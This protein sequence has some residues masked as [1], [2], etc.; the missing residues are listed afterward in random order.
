MENGILVIEHHL[1]NPYDLPFDDE[2]VPRT[3]LGGEIHTVQEFDPSMSYCIEARVISHASPNGLVTSFFTYGYD[4]G[5]SDEID[6]EFLSNK[7]NDDTTYPGGDPLLTNP[8]NESHQCPE[9]V[10]P[11]GL[12]LTKWN[13]F[14]IYWYPQPDAKCPAGGCIQWWWLDPVNGETWL[15]TEEVDS[16]VPDEPMALYFNF[17][18]PCYTGWGNGCG[19]WDE[20][21]DANLQ[22]VNTVGQNQ[23]Y[24]YEIDYVEVR[25][26]PHGLTESAKLPALGAAASDRFGASF[27]TSG[28]VPVVGAPGTAGTDSN[29]SSAYV[30]SCAPPCVKDDDCDDGSAC[31][32]DT[33]VATV[34]CQFVPHDA[35]PPIIV[36]YAGHEGSTRPCSGYIDPRIE[37]SNGM[38]LDRGVTSVD[39]HFS[40]PVYNVCG[41]AVDATSFVVTETGAGAQPEVLG[42]MK[43]NDTSYRLTLTRVITL[44]EW[45]TIRAAV[46]DECGNP[47]LNTG[48]GGPNDEPDRVDV[49]RLPGDVDQNAAVQ[50]V[51]LIRFRQGCAGGFLASCEP[52]SYY[53]DIDRNEVPCQPV[54]LI[55]LRQIFAGTPPATRPWLGKTMNSAR[56]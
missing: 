38:A 50:P 19:P 10:I 21:A 52:M 2:T 32:D 39:I 43:L 6:F 30:L 24:R 41:G 45:T 20:A 54:D 53:F 23:I 29:S 25:A 18:A 5:R 17:W 35:I 22:P 8:W 48:P 16:C 37:S 3:F 15:R 12:D 4:S 56:P 1:F 13:T 44:Q 27:A 51:D 42:V 36:H 31:T 14:R 47:I 33:C 11:A 34:G 26:R 7:T 28:D 9:C 46:E 49:A 55:R 40:G